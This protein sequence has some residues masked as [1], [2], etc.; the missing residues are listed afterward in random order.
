MVLLLNIYGPYYAR[1]E[2]HCTLLQTPYGAL[3][4]AMTLQSQLPRHSEAGAPL[5]AAGIEVTK[6]AVT[7]A[8]KV[9]HF[10][11]RFPFFSKPWKWHVQISQLLRQ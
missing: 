6:G 3:E 1:F 9:T 2:N 4:A 5:P 10:L 8:P 7:P 11:P